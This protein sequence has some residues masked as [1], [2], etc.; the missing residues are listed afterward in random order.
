MQRAGKESGLLQ[1]V[2]RALTDAVQPLY[3]RVFIASRHAGW[4]FET[5]VPGSHT[6]SSILSS[7]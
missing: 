1:V 6:P 4:P 2:L 7:A 5:Q 3:H